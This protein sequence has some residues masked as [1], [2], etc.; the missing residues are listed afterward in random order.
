MSRPLALILAVS[1][2]AGGILT[3]ALLVS[4]AAAST[5]AAAPHIVARPNSVMVNHTTKLTGKHFAAS[6]RITLEECSQSTFVVMSNPCDSTNTIKV[7]T[8]AQGRFQTTFT[9]NTCPGGT[10]TPPGFQQT[11]YIGE[12]LPSGVDTI[13]LQGSVTISIT[14]PWSEPSGS[15]RRT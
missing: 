3:D 9:V 13:S 6:K 5:T 15:R 11:C 14:G 4:S 2:A 7:K 1:V 8:N 10:I 12:P